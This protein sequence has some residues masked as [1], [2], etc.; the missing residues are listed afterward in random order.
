MKPEKGNSNIKQQVRDIGNKFLNNVEISAQEAVYIILQLPMRKSS[1]EVVFINTAP[2]EDRVELL[3]P[4]NDIKQMEDDCEEIFTS[5]LLKKYT[6]RPQ[7]LEHVTLA[8]F[9]AWY[10]IS[11]KPAYVK[12]T[13]EVDVD[14][15]PLETNN[16]D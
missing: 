2:P 12:K 9:A 13:F 6:Q 10:N 16:Y 7:R 4:I 5:S 15:L 3:K 11:Y 14:N 1:R 8:D